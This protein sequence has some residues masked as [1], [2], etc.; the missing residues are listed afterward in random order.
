MKLSEYYDLLR[1]GTWWIKSET[2]PR[3]NCVGRG[4]VGGLSMPTEA[5]RK[6]GWLSKEYGPPPVD[7]EGGYVKD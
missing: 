7:L 3:W 4:M 5:E 2:D 6:L 1:E